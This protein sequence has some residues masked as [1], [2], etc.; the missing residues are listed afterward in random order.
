MFHTQALCCFRSGL[1]F[2]L[3]TDLQKRGFGWQEKPAFTRSS[4]DGEH[5]PH[6]VPQAREVIEERVLAETISSEIQLGTGVKQENPVA[7]RSG[8]SLPA[9]AYDRVLRRRH[10]SKT[11]ENN[12]Q[13]QSRNSHGG[14]T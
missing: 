14:V 6:S 9:L 2:R 3:Q 5:G 7:E 11:D 13:N 4:V 12:R 8:G 1:N 10:A